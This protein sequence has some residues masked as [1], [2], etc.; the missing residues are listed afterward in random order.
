MCE[1][2]QK[3]VGKEI[4]YTTIGFLKI[5][6]CKLRTRSRRPGVYYEGIFF[7]IVERLSFLVSGTS[8]SL[9]IRKKMSP[10]SSV[11]SNSKQ[12]G[13]IRYS[14]ESGVHYVNLI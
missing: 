9:K 11:V 10:I 1:N 4:L 6:S 2:P 12:G 7:I 13:N 14:V 3:A 8:G 5:S